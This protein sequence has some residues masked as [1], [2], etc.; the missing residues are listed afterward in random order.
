[1]SPAPPPTSVPALL[2]RAEG[3]AG[4]TLTELADAM[5]LCVPAD[6]TRAKGW[7]GRLI[8]DAL[9]VP[10]HGKGPDFPEWGIELKTAPVAA[11]GV[12]LESTFVASVPFTELQD[13]DW[14]DS[15]VRRK[16]ARVL[17]IPVDGRRQVPVGQRRVGTPLL[18]TL[19]AEQERAL[20]DDWNQLMALI[21][22]GFGASL[23]GSVGRY[24][25]VRPKG[26]NKHSQRWGLDTE[27]ETTRVSPRAFYLRPAFVAEIFRSTFMTTRPSR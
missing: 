1:M 20:A 21:L 8:E 14:A 26:R 2:A 24:L 16:L 22:P 25:H 9:G 3:W 7:V 10:N 5:S 17:W 19:T 23:S 27:G 11:S 13:G 4:R 12:P 18:W 15:L 6:L